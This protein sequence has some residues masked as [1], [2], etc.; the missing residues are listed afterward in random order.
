MPSIFKD[1]GGWASDWAGSIT[2]QNAAND[3]LEAQTRATQDANN[4]QRYMYDQSRED[5]TPWREAGMR[6]LADLEGGKIGANLQQD[7]GFQFRM[8]EAMKALEK[9]ASARGSL[10]SGATLKA[11]TRYGQDYASN[12]YQNA[13]NRKASLAGVGQSATNTMAN[14]GQNYANQYGQNM[15]A[16]GNAQGAAAM[17]GYSGMKDLLL[18][19]GMIWAQRGSGSSN[20]GNQGVVASDSNLKKN[21]KPMSKEVDD[22]LSKI[23]PYSFEYISKVHGIGPRVGIMAQDLEK[24]KLGKNAVVEQEDGKAVDIGK[25]VGLLLASVARLNERIDKLENKLEVSNAG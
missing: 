18:G 6:A 23:K 20:K 21:I 2:G 1:P 10:N 25:A 17:Q 19:G 5:M 14:L 4:V 16:L 13:Y 3:A 15:M 22:L 24:S 12:E 8:G 9:S 11:L 7:P